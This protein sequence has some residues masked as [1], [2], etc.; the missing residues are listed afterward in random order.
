MLFLIT[1]YS[2]H[3]IAYISPHVKIYTYGLKTSYILINVIQ[4]IIKH[5]NYL[6]SSKDCVCCYICPYVTFIVWV[7]HDQHL[8]QWSKAELVTI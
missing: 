8:L 6:K 3:I 1:R 2:F 4:N 7:M 5:I